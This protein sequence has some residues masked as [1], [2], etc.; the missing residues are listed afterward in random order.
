MGF[1]P[2]SGKDGQQPPPD[3]HRRRE[4]EPEARRAAE[5]DYD[6]IAG[7]SVGEDY[8]DDGESIV[9]KQISLTEFVALLQRI[10]HHR[11]QLNAD[12]ETLRSW[13]NNS[14]LAAAWGKFTA[15]GGISCADFLNFMQGKQGPRLSPLCQ[16]RHLRLVVSQDKSPRRRLG[17]GGTDDAA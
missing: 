15:N 16:R 6:D 13:L 10:E 5:V 3:K 7:L 1:F 9:R 11:G 17:S 14:Q 12:A 2:N 8:D 4:R